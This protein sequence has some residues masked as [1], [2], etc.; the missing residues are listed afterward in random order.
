MTNAFKTTPIPFRI[1]RR[2]ILSAS[3]DAHDRAK[4]ASEKFGPDSEQARLAWEEVADLDDKADFGQAIKPPMDE[5]CDIEK[6]TV[7]CMEFDKQMS[8]LR[9]LQS[10][11]QSIETDIEIQIENLYRLKLDSPVVDTGK[12]NESEYNAAKAEAE[13]AVRNFGTDSAEARAAWDIVNEIEAADDEQIKTT[14]LDD[15]CLISTSQKCIEYKMALDQLQQAI[16]TSEKND[17]NQSI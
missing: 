1:S 17:F 15:E 8:L 5:E 12:I 7:K 4:A 9:E 11:A 6:D 2:F 13:A 10:K 14:S 3:G 16:V